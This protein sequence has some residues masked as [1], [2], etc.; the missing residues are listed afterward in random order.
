VVVALMYVDQKFNPQK[1]G[2]TERLQASTIRSY[3]GGLNVADTDLNM[4]PSY[5]KVLDNIERST[6][7]TLSIR[8]GTLFLSSVGDSAHYIVN[9][10]YFNGYV[11]SVMDDGTFW[12]TNGAGTT[13]QM[14]LVVGGGNP[15]TPGTTFVSFTIF[16]SD[17]LVANGKD[18]PIIISGNPNK[19]NYMLPDFIQDLANGTNVNTPVGAFITSHGQ[20]TIIAGIP[21]E[22]S[23]IYISA[24][25]TSGTYLNDPA[26]NDAVAIDL[27]PRVS[28]GSATITG[29]ISYRDKLMVMFERG[30]LPMNLGVYTGTTP[31]HTPTDDGFIEEFGCASHRSMHSVGDDMF[32]CDNVGVIS[33]NRIAVF[34]TLRPIRASQLIDPLITA[35][36]STLSQAQISKYVFSVY[37]LRHF[38]Y[39]L[40][41]PSFD[42]GGNLVETVGFSYTN[43]P[44][45]KVSAWARL[46]GWTWQCG[47]RTALQ[48]VIF[49]NGNKLYAYDFAA[50]DTC[51]DFRNDPAV[52]SGVGLPVTFD[53]ELPWADFKQRTQTKT[54]R[55]LGLDTQGTG[56]FTAELYADNY[57]TYNGSRVPLL[58]MDF[59]GGDAAG[60]GAAPYGDSPYGGGRRTSEERLYAYVAKFKLM[61]LRFFGTTRN[62]VKF[63]SISVLYM[64]GTVRR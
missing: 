6:D 60:Y 25:G 12:Q 3:S 18:K 22:P 29:V 32:Y 55:Y 58:S 39:M 21:A 7:G 42:S 31:V 38:R 24:K 41:I 33:T 53:W 52:D 44:T 48:N 4:S 23:Y 28:I 20:Y 36:M 56:K 26:P 61:K 9:C 49:A 5:A 19:P 54:M 17:L 43:I 13:T 51:I 15:F 34:N 27:G 59:L 50:T 40:F 11:I 8:P 2:A 47:C 63:I 30:A 1:I 57:Y 35:M 37:D 46:R 45:L 14:T 16:N 10:T 64:H 62:K